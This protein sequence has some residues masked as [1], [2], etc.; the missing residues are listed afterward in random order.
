MK[1]T[2]TMISMPQLENCSQ[3]AAESLIKVDVIQ[4]EP[5]ATAKHSSL[6]DN[7]VA[8]GFVIEARKNQSCEPQLNRRKR[9]ATHSTLVSKRDPKQSLK[10]LHL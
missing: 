4:A 5:E 1:S 8:F 3:R 2:H 6:H 9:A 10:Q 7:V